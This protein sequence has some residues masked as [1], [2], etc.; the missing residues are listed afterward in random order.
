MSTKEGFNEMYKIVCSMLA[1]PESTVFR[2]P[3]DWKGLGLVD[4]PEIIKKPMDLG[5]I[6][7]KIESEKYET[8]EEIAAVIRLVWTNCMLYNRDGSEVS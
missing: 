4:Y 1:R 3:V 7:G 6:K 5:T 8:Y 2:E